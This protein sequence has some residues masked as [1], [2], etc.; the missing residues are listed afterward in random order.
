MSATVAPVPVD[1]GPGA[2]KNNCAELGESADQLLG[3]PSHLLRFYAVECGLK[4]A[5]LRRRGLRSTSQLD[6][7][8]RHHDLRRLAR[9]L[10]LDAT[11]YRRLGQCRQRA[12]SRRAGPPVEP[13]EMHQAWRY[14]LGVDPRDEQ[15]FVAGLKSLQRWCREELGR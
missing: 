10:R 14:G 13:A 12:H 9:E 8:L 4:A 15:I 7:D 1:I 3:P 11:T 6:P 2:L 5:L